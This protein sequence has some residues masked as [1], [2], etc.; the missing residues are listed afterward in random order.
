[1]REGGKGRGKGERRRERKREEGGEE[2]GG[3]GEGKREGRGAEGVEKGRGTV[4]EEWRV[5]RV[6]MRESGN[7]RINQLMCTLH[8]Q[9]LGSP[10]G[11]DHDGGT[12]FRIR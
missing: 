2:G 7:E 3:R 5:S 1:M 6:V 4:G 10:D 9:V 8:T 12:V 11:G